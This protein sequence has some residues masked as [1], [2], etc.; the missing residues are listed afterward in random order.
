MKKMKLTVPHHNKVL[1]REEL[2]LVVGGETRSSSTCGV[3]CDQSNNDS[4]PIENCERATVEAACGS[5]AMNDGS[6]VCICM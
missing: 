4:Q 5:S 2:K 1:T 6:V 3:R